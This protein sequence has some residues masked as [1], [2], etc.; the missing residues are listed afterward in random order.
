MNI[1]INVFLWLMIYGCIGWIYESTLCSI[2]SKKLVNRGMLRG[3]ICPIYGF[4]A[5]AI[6]F[7]LQNVTHNPLA[8][9]FSSMVVTC[10]LEY[11]TSYVLEKLFHTK[12]WDYSYM[13]FQINGRVCLAGALVFASL[14]MVLMYY[15]HPYILTHLDKFDIQFRAGVA[16]TLFAVFVVDIVTTVHSLLKMNEHVKH[17]HAEISVIRKEMEEKLQS[18]SEELRETIHAEAE[19]R[20]SGVLD[21]LAIKKSNLKHMFRAYPNA[22]SLEYPESFM[23]LRDRQKKLM[24]KIKDKVK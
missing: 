11:I 13:K 19:E 17:I 2:T 20:I 24:E 22:I 1:L 23:R 16:I 9:F 12:W 4:G 5:L 18:A 7:S 3:P 14:S 15:V 6:I 10:T 8:L 21:N